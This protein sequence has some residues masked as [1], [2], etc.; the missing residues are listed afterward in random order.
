MKKQ[1]V[2]EKL[3][4]AIELI[5]F[6]GVLLLIWLDEY[7]DLPF[8]YLGAPKTPP[9]PQEFWF[10][11]CAVLFA[12]DGDRGRNALGFSAAAFFRRFHPRLRLVSQG[13]SGR[14]MGHI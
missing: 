5:G 10:E 13:G 8:R 2:Y 14:G 6:G 11:T 4:L 12:R 1:H 3:I 9:R 7:L